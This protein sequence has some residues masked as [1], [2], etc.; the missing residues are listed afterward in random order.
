MTDWQQL[1]TEGRDL[2]E[3]ASHIQN[4]ETVGLDKNAID[5]LIRDYHDWFAHCMAVLSEDLR[6]KFRGEYEG[7]IF[8]YRIKKFFQGPTQHNIFYK[9]GDETTKGI[10]SPWTFPYEQNFHPALLSQL[11]I[12]VEVSKR[13]EPPTLHKT[14]QQTTSEQPVSLASQSFLLL[15]ADEELRRRCEDLLSA[16]QHFDRVIREACVVLENRVRSLIQADA[17]ITGTPLMELALSP[18]APRLR[19]SSVE[20]EQLGAMQLYRG[21]MAF[22]RN[23]AGH[24]VIDTYTQEDAC[25]FVAWIDLL[26]QMVQVAVTASLANVA[27]PAPSQSVSG[28]D[29]SS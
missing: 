28:K 15:I 9:S 6:N 5:H 18:K 4:G 13:Q 29:V 7:T 14:H 12:L 11:Q 1:I 21:T 23:Q 10:I 3:R 20:Q 2:D 8:S 17:Q 27:P 22:F 26:L 19:L 25:R 24:H 16:E